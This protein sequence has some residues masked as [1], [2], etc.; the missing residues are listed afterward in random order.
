MN[1]SAHTTNGHTLRGAVVGVG[2]LGTFHAQKY[3]HSPLV[4][5]EGVCDASLEQAQKVATQLGCK[6]FTS[7]AELIGKVD[8]VTIAATTTF[9]FELA[10]LFLQNGIHVN[11]EKPITVTTEQA[12]KLIA[13]AKANNVVLSVGHVERFNPVF[14]E[15]KKY[16]KNPSFAE[17][18]RLAPFKIRGSDVS[19]L[20]DLMIHDI[21]LM[22]NLEQQFAS[23]NNKK[24]GQIKSVEGFA[25]A[26][27]TSNPDVASAFF[28]F[29]SG[30]KARI[31]VSRVAASGSRTVKIYDEN[32]YFFANLTSGEIEKM[33]PSARAEEPLLVEKWI[34]PK[35]DAL[36]KET[37]AFLRA[38]L[39]KTQ[40]EVTGEDGLH[41]LELVERVLSGI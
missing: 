17:F 34:A 2:Y 9:H 24:P 13:L 31:Q 21:D 19:V 30:F 11:V 39:D 14:R 15:L 36:E 33:T 6:A 22:L 27:V 20:H 16:L 10:S 32:N 26:Y 28:E 35:W 7:P 38:V 37:E 41:A 4:K 25:K 23:A 5:L 40:A 12:Q 29:K 18:E 8:V 3:H 1:N